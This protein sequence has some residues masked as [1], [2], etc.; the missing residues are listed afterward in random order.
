MEEK[1][2][3]VHGQLQ[4]DNGSAKIINASLSYP[5]LKTGGNSLLLDMAGANGTY[6]VTRSLEGSFSPGGA[7]VWLSFL[8]K[9]DKIGDGHCFL[10]FGDTGIGKQWA[11]GVSVGSI[12]AQLALREGETNLIVVKIEALE[13]NDNVHVWTNPVVSANE[14]DIQ[15]TNCYFGNNLD[16]GTTPRFGMNLQ[17]HGEG[18]YVIDELRIGDS[19]TDVM[20]A[21]GACPDADNDGVCDADDKCPQGNDK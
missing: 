11:N 7:E 19:F 4:Q 9:A 16:M 15:A 10:L 14:P 8:I 1:G 2:L 13:G 21:E 17:Y 6:E 3:L 20:P 18:Q 5:N 12:N